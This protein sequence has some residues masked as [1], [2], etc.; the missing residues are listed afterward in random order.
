MNVVW[1][2]TQH[3]TLAEGFVADEHVSPLTGKDRVRVVD[4]IS[5][6]KDEDAGIHLDAAH[7]YSSPEAALRKEKSNGP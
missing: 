4:F 3:N 6:A 2:I 1:Y 7:C 5:E